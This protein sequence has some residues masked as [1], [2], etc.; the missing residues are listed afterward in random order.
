MSCL[1][2]EGSSVFKSFTNLFYLLLSCSV[3][4][5]IGVNVGKD[6]IYFNRLKSNVMSH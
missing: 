4:V 2:S 5:N 3:K 1:L 6:I